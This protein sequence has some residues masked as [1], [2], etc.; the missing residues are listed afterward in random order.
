[1]QADDTGIR[2]SYLKTQD[3]VVINKETGTLRRWLYATKANLGF[4]PRIAI[5]VS[6]LSSGCVSTL[7]GNDEERHVE[8]ACIV[9][10]GIMKISSPEE[11]DHSLTYRDC[12][13]IP[14]GLDYEIENVG[15]SDLKIAWTMAPSFDSPKE[16]LGSMKTHEQE[17]LKVVRT[18]IDV[19]PVQITLPG[20]ERSIYKIDHPKN[21]RFALFTRKAHT[22]SPLHTHDP[23]DFEEGYVVLQ[24]SLKLTDLKGT[25]SMLREGDFAY[26][27]PFSGNFNENVSNEEVHYLWSGAP[28]VSMREVPVDPRFAKYQDVMSLAKEGQEVEEQ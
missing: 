2:S 16:A 15:Y 13:Y 28:A 12:A 17:E 22:Y 3:P 14:A 10:S 5:G 18:L 7:Y 23:P 1:M 21:F 26:V 25:S 4:V 19:K 27:P 11:N 9:I 20:L 24:G 6:I 8:K